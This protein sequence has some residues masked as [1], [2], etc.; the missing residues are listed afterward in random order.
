M[1]SCVCYVI[2]VRTCCG[3]LTNETN[4][5]TTLLVLLVKLCQQLDSI[6]AVNV[7]FRGYNVST[8]PETPMDCLLLSM[9]YQSGKH[10]H[11]ITLIKQ[12]SQHSTEDI[13]SNIKHKSEVYYKSDRIIN[14]I[15]S[16]PEYLCSI[17]LIGSRSLVEANDT[18]YSSGRYKTYILFM[19][20]LTARVLLTA[21][22]LRACTQD[23]AKPR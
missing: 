2:Y 13:N 3:Q 14:Q 6:Q 17:V 11:L 7:A 8:L 20:D 9:C 1:N 19:Q 21:N 23:S 22:T 15:I 12:S 5:N 4:S 10:T 16:Y 18:S